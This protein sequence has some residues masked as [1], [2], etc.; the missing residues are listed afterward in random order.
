MS[1]AVV[2]GEA[3]VRLVHSPE[4]RDRLPCLAE[5][6][7]SSLS[8]SNSP[9]CKSCNKTK[10][11]TSYDAHDVQQALAVKRCLY[12]ASGDVHALAKSILNVEQLVFY[13]AGI[14]GLPPRV[15]K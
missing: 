1:R 5:T 3:L 10:Q 8:R 2:A 14:P 15:V 12:E 9:D 4:L 11:V 13:F 7:I 6:T